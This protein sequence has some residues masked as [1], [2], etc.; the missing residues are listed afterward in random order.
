MA[1]TFLR[2]GVPALALVPLLLAGPALA[3]RPRQPPRPGR[4]A[5]TSR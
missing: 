4:I 5:F 1:S 3:H 2:R